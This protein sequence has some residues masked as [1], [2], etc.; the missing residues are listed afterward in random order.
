MFFYICGN[1]FSHMVKFFYICDKRIATFVVKKCTY[2]VGLF[3]IVVD[4]YI[5]DNIF[6]LNEHSDQCS[7]YNTL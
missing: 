2:V 1:F 6:S 5:C 3:Y 4:F 7:H